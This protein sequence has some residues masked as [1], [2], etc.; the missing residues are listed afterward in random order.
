[1]D[2]PE[3]IL[4]TCIVFDG[5]LFFYENR[6]LEKFSYIF[7]NKG[8]VVYSIVEEMKKEHDF[9]ESIASTEVIID[10]SIH[11]WVDNKILFYVPIPFRRKN[12]RGFPLK[13]IIHF[14][15]NFIK[16]TL[17]AFNATIIMFVLFTLFFIYK[18]YT[19]PFMPIYSIIIFIIILIFFYLIQKYFEKKYMIK[20]FREILKYYNIN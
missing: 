16:L 17:R 14:N 3:Y 4:I 8:V 18:T 11:K 1:M 13:G 20:V 2:L 7:Y 9:K 19:T 10:K 15:K 12:I 6:R 5:I